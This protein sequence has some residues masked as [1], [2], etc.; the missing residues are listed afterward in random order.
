MPDFAATHASTASTCKIWGGASD[1]W[2]WK[3][4]L[5]D[6]PPPIMEF[7]IF[8][9]KK[10]WTFPLV[11]TYKYYNRNWKKFLKHFCAWVGK[12]QIVKPVLLLIDRGIFM[13]DHR[14]LCSTHRVK[15]HLE[16]WLSCI[17]L[18]SGP[19]K[20]RDNQ[21]IRWSFMKMTLFWF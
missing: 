17:R 19:S 16:V 12:F 2:I 3:M 4:T 9:K 10:F 8:L 14:T 11:G 13:K 18:L 15:D 21:N 7:S 20:L 6:P 5:A 1:Y